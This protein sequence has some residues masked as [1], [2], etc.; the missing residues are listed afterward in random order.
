MGIE[1]LWWSK[2]LASVNKAALSTMHLLDDE[3]LTTVADLATEI[4]WMVEDVKVERHE[5]L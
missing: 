3:A 5:H 2:T 1:E 4:L